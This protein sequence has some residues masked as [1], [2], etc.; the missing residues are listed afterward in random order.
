MPEAAEAYYANVLAGTGY[1]IFDPKAM[2]DKQSGRFVLAAFAKRNS[3]S[4]S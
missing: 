2:Y 3:D 1:S 4:T